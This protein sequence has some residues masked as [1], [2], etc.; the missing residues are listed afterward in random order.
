M[1]KKDLTYVA[2]DVETAGSRLGYHPTLSIGASLI[3]RQPMLFAERE[4]NGLIFYAELNPKIYWRYE[5][6]AMRVGCSQLI[7]L[8]SVKKR[9]RRFD[10]ASESFDCRDTLELMTH[11]CEDTSLALE[12]FRVWLEKVSSCKKIEGVTDTVFFDAGRIGLCFGEDSERLMPFGWTGLD[13]DSAY[14]GY[15]RNPDANLRELGVPDDRQKPHRADHDAVLLA[16][17]ARVFLFEKMGW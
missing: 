14:R 3:T 2:L 10:P 9:N 7:C 5:I 17:I 12:R 13:L 16:E 1:D 6:E 8:E 4:K 15:T 11:A